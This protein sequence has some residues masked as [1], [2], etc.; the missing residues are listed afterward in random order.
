MPANRNGKR[1]P[2]EDIYAVAPVSLTYQRYSTRPAQWWIGAALRNLASASGI[3][4][5]AFD[6]LSIAS[7]TL[8]PDPAIAM[9][10][11]FGMT[12]RWI[13]SMAMGGA[14]GVA[15]I[16]RAA[17]ALEAGDVDIVAC[18]GADTNYTDT[19]RELLAGFSR[20]S[21]DAVYPHGAGG[22]N[23]S[24]AHLTNAYMDRFGVTR[25]DFGRICVSQRQNALRNPRAIM[26]KPLTLDGY[27]SARPIVDPLGLFDCVMPVAGAEAFLL[28]RGDTM[29]HH[30]LTGARLLSSI[31]R[32]NA[33]PDDPVQYRGGWALDVEVLYGMAGVGPSD[34]DVLQT[35]DDYPVIVMMQFEDLGF[36]AK[37]E[38]AAFVAGNDLTIGGSFPHNTTG[39]Q[40]S[41]GQAGAAGGHLGIVETIRQVTGTAAT[42][43]VDGAR[44]GMASGFGMINYDRGLASG[45]VIFAGD[46]V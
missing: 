6:G 5:T 34:I 28:M 11:H 3:P 36:C 41:A 30:G 33:F 15:A 35:Y 21:Q 24:F 39:G 40:L 17:R 38:G 46:D 18:I 2:Y 37:G 26:K 4:H 32:H 7:F 9:T 29:R 13:D 45:A 19:F 16:R 42:T 10:Q 1:R 22:A 44:L 43:Q 20:F 8:G 27:L 31:E 23:A 14:S 25:E 12:T